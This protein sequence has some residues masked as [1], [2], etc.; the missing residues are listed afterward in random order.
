[1]EVEDDAAQP[2]TD[3]PTRSEEQWQSLQPYQDEPIANAAWIAEYNEVRRGEK[4][5][6][7]NSVNWGSAHLRLVGQIIVKC[8]YTN[9]RI[10]SQSFLFCLGV[11]V[12]TA[13]WIS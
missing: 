8:V 5:T 7:C 4:T 2:P 3:S 9:T 1:M 13:R 6:A 10:T 11:H 12:K